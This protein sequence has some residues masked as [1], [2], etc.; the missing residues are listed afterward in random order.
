[1]KKLALA[2]VATAA[3]A[4]QAIAADMPMKAR[5]MAQPAPVYNWTGCNINGGGGYGWYDIENRQVD[6][7]TGAFVARQGDSGGRGWI[8]SGRRRLR[9]SVRWSVG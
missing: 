3:F 2:L 1:M 8:G 9:L 6:P 7:V 5:P 4:G